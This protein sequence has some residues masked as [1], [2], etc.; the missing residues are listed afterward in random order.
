MQSTGLP[1]GGRTDFAAPGAARVLKVGGDVQLFCDDF[2]LTRG[3][4]ASRDYPV[5]IRFTP[6]PAV[7][8]LEPVMLPGRDATWE[9]GGIY[10]MT[11]LHDGGRFRCWYNLGK[12]SPNSF[13]VSYLRDRHR[14][15][16]LVWA[17]GKG[18]IIA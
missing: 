11:V 8:D 18:A 16:L 7:K 5:N 17:L 10:W 9:T 2:L 15:P 4:A 1:P 3:T 14:R 6:G 13:L 12:F